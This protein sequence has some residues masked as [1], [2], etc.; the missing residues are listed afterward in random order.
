MP[1]S[2]LS[3]RVSEFLGVVLFATALFWLIALATYDTHRAHEQGTR[4]MIALQIHRRLHG[5]YPETLDA[6]APDILPEIPVDS[7]SG[8]AFVYRLDGD[9]YLLYSMG[10]DGI[11]DS[12]GITGPID[13]AA[14]P[15]SMRYQNTRSGTDLPLNLSRDEWQ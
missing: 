15:P 8:G 3:R 11:D 4:I 1:G 10:R 2:T 9:G 13:P 6:L 5:A 14:P 12:A 7:L